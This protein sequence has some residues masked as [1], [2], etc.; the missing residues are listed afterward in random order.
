LG[1]WH[2]LC[3]RRDGKK[4]TIEK[5]YASGSSDDTKKYQNELKEV[6]NKRLERDCERLRRAGIKVD[7]LAF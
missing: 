2:R 6:A 5:I 1:S 4:T 7:K 3:L